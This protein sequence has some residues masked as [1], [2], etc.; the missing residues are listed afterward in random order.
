[1]TPGGGDVGTGLEGQMRYHR[2]GVLWWFWGVGHTCMSRLLGG[3]SRELGLEPWDPTSQ[4]VACLS[5]EGGFQGS[6]QYLV[7]YWSE[8]YLQ[9]CLGGSGS[10]RG[11]APGLD[12][13]DGTHWGP[14]RWGGMFA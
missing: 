14:L 2:N 8:K 1:M 13:G 6:P 10:E 3:D 5:Y 12:C 11:K 9:R 7:P 4:P